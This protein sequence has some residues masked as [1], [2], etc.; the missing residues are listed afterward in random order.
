MLEPPVDGHGP[1]PRR[2]GRGPVGAILRPTRRLI[3]RPVQALAG[4]GGVDLARQLETALVE[5]AE[6]DAAERTLDSLLAGPLP[7]RVG[8]SLARHRVVERTL[9]AATEDGELERAILAALGTERTTRLLEELVRTPAFSR[10]L[11]Q[12]LASPSVRTGL[13]EQSA[14]FAAETAAA[15]R[16][17]AA[18]LDDAAERGPRRLFGRAGDVAARSRYG[19]VAT[20]AFAFAVDA[21]LVTCGLL[22]ATALAGLAAS[23]VG[24]VGQGRLADALVGAGWLL[25]AGVYFAGFWA[26]VGQTPGMRLLRVR[27]LSPAGGPPGIGRSLL[28]LAG[29]ALAIAPC[30]AGFLPIL[31]DRRRRGLHDL[32][33]G[34]V[35]VRDE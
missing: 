33:A 28:R 4:P 20:R 14:S 18:G 12:V 10:A 7:E 29:L 11:E 24:G 32:L 30:F 6:T 27:V 8:G 3:A 35:V 21:A 31:F 34:T 1:A 19:G 5:A 16:R 22:V 2:A 15:G 13:A 26:T 17:R 23:L 9:A 25:V